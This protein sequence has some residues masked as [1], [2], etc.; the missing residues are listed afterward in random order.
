MA[1]AHAPQAKEKGTKVINEDGL[2]ALI[3]ATSHLRPAPSPPAADVLP[4]LRVS[5]P[6]AA[7]RLGASAPGGGAICLPGEAA[8]ATPHVHET[9]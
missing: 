6:A 7:S 8:A 9:G 1:P 5:A 4:P 3:A 2:F